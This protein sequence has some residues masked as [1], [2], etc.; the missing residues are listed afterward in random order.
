M[1]NRCVA[2]RLTAHSYALFP[3]RTDILFLPQD[4]ANSHGFDEPPL[5]KTKD[6]QPGSS[7]SAFSRLA[8]CPKMDAQLETEPCFY[9]RYPEEK[10]RNQPFQADVFCL[11]AKQGFVNTLPNPAAQSPKTQ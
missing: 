6:L 10:Q 7:K 5:Q 1:L 3:F 8:N 4:G 11:F 9:N 2:T